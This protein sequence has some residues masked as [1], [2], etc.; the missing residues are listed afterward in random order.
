MLTS[1][2][3]NPFPADQLAFRP[4]IVKTILSGSQREDHRV[5]AEIGRLLV[6]EKRSHPEGRIIELALVRLRSTAQV[7]GPPIVLLAGGPGVSGID[8]LR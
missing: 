3:T 5:A 6:P 1:T 7:S 8:L 2:Q 4:Y